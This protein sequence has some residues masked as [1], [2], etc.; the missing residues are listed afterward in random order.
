MNDLVIK[1]QL[2]TATNKLYDGVNGRRYLTFHE[3]ANTTP[4]ANAQAHAN[5]QSRNNVRNASWHWQVDDRWAIKSFPHTSRCWHAG[6]GRGPGNLSSI[7]VEICVNADGN[8]EQTIRNAILLGNHIMAEEGID[9]DHVVN[10]HYWS[11]KNCPTRLL[12]GIGG[13]TWSEFLAMLDPDPT[14]PPKPWGRLNPPLTPDGI[15]GRKTIMGWQQVMGTPADGEVWMPSAVIRADQRWLNEAL[16]S[17]H[18]QNLTGKPGLVEDGI[19]GWRTI[20]C[21]SFL[22]HNRVDPSL[23]IG[24]RLTSHHIATHQIALNRAVIGSKMY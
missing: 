10:H 22:L 2:V 3:T 14:A 21:R 19:E 16:G 4:G 6:D 7:A 1:E 5:L 20:I 18:I 24:Q 13:T 11:G 12:E 17:G 8:W 23:A 9:L 15:R